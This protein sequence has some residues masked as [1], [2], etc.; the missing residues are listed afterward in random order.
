MPPAQTLIEAAYAVTFLLCWS[1]GVCLLLSL[2]IP[3]FRQRAFWKAAFLPLGE[4][5]R[6][7]GELPHTVL[8]NIGNS[9]LNRIGQRLGATGLSLGLLTGIAWLALRI[10]QG[11]HP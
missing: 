4:R 6:V 1:G 3:L 11:P 8:Q 5:T 7:Q 2:M 10:I 9:R